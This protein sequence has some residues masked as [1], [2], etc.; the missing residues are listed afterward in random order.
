MKIQKYINND[1]I[2][3]SASHIKNIVT[4]LPW[5]IFKILV[6]QI[7]L[8]N[9]K[10]ASTGAKEVQENHF[11]CLHENVVLKKQIT[12]FIQKCKNF[13]D[14]WKFNVNYITICPHNLIGQTSVGQKIGLVP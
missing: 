4:I 2:M 10:K 9:Q 13:C 11:E 12:K 8:T 3:F 14:F 1:I 6:F 7:W 5:K